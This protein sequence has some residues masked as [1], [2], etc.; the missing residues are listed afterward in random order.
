MDRV[1]EEARLFVERGGHVVITDV[2]DDASEK[3]AREL[4][5]QAVYCHLDVR[6][7]RWR[8]SHRSADGH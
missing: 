6:E 5:D 8:S 7:T 2:F 1:P 3:L 4:A